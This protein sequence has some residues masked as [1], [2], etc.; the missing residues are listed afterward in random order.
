MAQCD[1]GSV[2]GGLTLLL[3]GVNLCFSFGNKGSHSSWFRTSH[4]AWPVSTVWAGRE[5]VMRRK[6]QGKAKGLQK[7][8]RGQQSP[9]L[10]ESCR[11]EGAEAGPGK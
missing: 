3:D 1:S 2:G 4:W 8:R 9:F 7:A 10:G 11:T 5:H 6:G